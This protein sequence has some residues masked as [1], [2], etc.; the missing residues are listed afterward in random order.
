M[1]VVHLLLCVMLTV[2]VLLLCT[3]H[4]LLNSIVAIVQDITE[5]CRMKQEEAE[6][7]AATAQ[8]NA[9]LSAVSAQHQQ[10]QQQQQQQLAS[11]MLRCSTSYMCQ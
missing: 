7:E 6:Q 4:A 10:Q 9:T 8:L 5:V 11:R 1:L 3:V 2:A